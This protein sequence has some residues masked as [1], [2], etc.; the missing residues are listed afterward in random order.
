MLHF[1]NRCF[2][3]QSKHKTTGNLSCGFPRRNR[4]DTQASCFP[5]PRPSSLFIFI[6]KAHLVYF[7]LSFGEKGATKGDCKT[8]QSVTPA[9]SAASALFLPSFQVFIHPLSSLCL[10]HPSLF[11]MWLS[12]THPSS[13]SSAVPSSEKSSPFLKSK[14]SGL[15]FYAHL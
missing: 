11:F 12:H 6:P 15:F 8:F 9:N 7:F 13:L 14:L 10:K 1:L 3:I 5:L 4:A 2:E